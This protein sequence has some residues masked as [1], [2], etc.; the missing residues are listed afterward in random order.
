[1]DDGSERRAVD[2]EREQHQARGEHRHESLHFRLQRGISQ[3]DGSERQHQGQ[4]AAQAAPGDSQLIGSADRLGQ[5]CQAQQRQKQ[6]QHQEA[7]REHGHDQRRD[8]HEIMELHVEQQLRHQDRSQHE[9]QRMR[10]E[11]YLGPEIGDERPI[12]G[13]YARPPGGADGQS[14]AENGD[15]A[16]H[17][18]DVLGGDEKRDRVAR[19]SASLRPAD[20][21]GSRGW[22]CSSA[23]SC[24]QAQSRP[25]K[26]GEQELLLADEEIR[27]ASGDDLAKQHREHEHDRRSRSLRRASPSTRRAQP[28]CAAPTFAGTTRSPLPGRWSPPPSRAASIP[29]AAG[30]R[31]ARARSRPRRC[32]RP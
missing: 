31:S 8:K 9:H 22:S 26:E 21:P 4:R 30:L 5:F 13:R 1:M 27:L 23:R 14:G 11:G 17:M 24:E 18:Q 3:C 2:Q 7:R 25:A 16:G 15:D 19:G 20:R 32:R 12:V 28:R 10:P 6:E 29:P